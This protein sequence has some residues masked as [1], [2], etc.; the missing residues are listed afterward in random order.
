MKYLAW[1]Y[2]MWCTLAVFAQCDARQAGRALVSDRYVDAQ[3]YGSILVLA[4]AHGLVFNQLDAPNA[5][6][7]ALESIPGQTQNVFLAGST[8]FVTS[9]GTGIFTYQFES[10][11]LPPVREGFTAVDAIVTATAIDET[12]FV[13]RNERLEAFDVSQG[14]PYRFID[15]APITGAVRKLSASE[16]HVALQ[17]EDG[18]IQI[19]SFD[20]QF[21]SLM[22]LQV[23]N[24]NAFYNM[25]FSGPQL[26]LD[27]SDGVRWVDLSPEG[28]AVNSGILVENRGAKI[29]LGMAQSEDLLYVRFASEFSVY[30]LSGRSASLIA[31]REIDL[32]EIRIPKMFAFG[33]DLMLLNQSK[34]RPW[35]LSWF[36]VRGSTLEPT[37]LVASRLDEITGV[38]TI[39][40]TVFV[41]ADRYVFY[42]SL[43]ENTGLGPVESMIEFSVG[44]TVLDMVSSPSQLVLTT[45]QDG[46][47][48][49]A[50]RVFE[51]SQGQ[52]V[53]RSNDIFVGS[54]ADLRHKDNHTSFVQSFR[55]AEADHYIAH[56]IDADLN[57][58]IITLN[59][60]LPIGS[61]N[62]FQFFQVRDQQI[63]YYDGQ[64]LVSHDIDRI[65]NA[66][67]IELGLDPPSVKNM[68]HL[69]NS[70]L[71]EL[72]TGLVELSWSGG[73]L[74][75]EYP[76]WHDLNLS[77][78]NHV[79]VQNREYQVP[80]QYF[81]LD[82][83][84]N[85]QHYALLDLSSSSA[86]KYLSFSD[87]F[88]AADDTSVDEFELSCPPLSY[89]YLIPYRDTYELDLSTDASENVVALLVAYN[90]ANQVI[91][92]QLMDRDV[93]GKLNRRR[94][95]DWFV[96][97]NALQ[98]PDTFVLISSE[99]LAAVVS[100][101][102]GGVNGRF[103]YTVIPN[104]GPDLLFPHV[105]NRNQ[106][107]T[108]ELH[109]RNNTVETTA[110]AILVPPKDDPLQLFLTPGGTRILEINALFPSTTRWAWVMHQQLGTD[111]DGFAR[112]RRVDIDDIAAV[113]LVHET[114]EFLV[115]PHVIGEADRYWTGLALTNPND[116]DVR[117]RVIGYDDAGSIAADRDLVI[118]GQGQFVVQLEE[119]LAQENQL[120]VR[121]LTVVSEL[122]IAGIEIFGSHDKQELAGT[123]LSAQSGQRL[124]FTGVRET[125][126]EGTRIVITNR[127]SVSG[128]VD[129]SAVNS[130]GR[131]LAKV[132]IAVGPKAREVLSIANLF[133]NVSP[134]QYADIHTIVAESSLDLTG[135][136]IRNGKREQWMATHAPTVMQ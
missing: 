36:R 23:A 14:L 71:F 98:T 22:S 125:E 132:S 86:P 4:N 6:F 17:F 129:V 119:W 59:R 47:N 130:A 81:V 88:L 8:L 51:F 118:E 37:A 18:R 28:E 48:A 108:S 107:W 131:R 52:L 103:A 1:L 35:S 110:D 97:V 13:A 50:V 29:V 60:D 7:M 117:V 83:D 74:I 63:A 99:P 66:R 102:V 3:L 134:L 20:G 85:G 44:E 40:D 5:N 122:P 126:R 105:A 124:L 2:M 79:L 24:F 61:P 57:K 33:Q 73:Q 100:G 101:T 77:K 114:S 49:T 80:G 127:D 93:I 116:R 135:L 68:V 94:F 15:A 78:S 16:G 10:P 41:A 69:G 65:E 9:K 109:L 19:A 62:P 58:S 111:L 84:E 75:S 21:G 87:R 42:Q 106:G 26:I 115:I 39:G 92:R 95:A 64:N 76:N 82:R 128:T 89:R 133:P 120:N 56:V 123:V 112:Y 96:D 67:M 31:S 30:R 46:A 121:W 25:A 90:T 12:L 136:V 72:S 32:S 70:V 91:G 11:E 54:L 55:D 113:P 45:I 43:T 27:A 34:S 53:E 38:A 104:S